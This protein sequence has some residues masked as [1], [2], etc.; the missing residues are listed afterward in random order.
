[1]IINSFISLI[2]II[3]I[4]NIF[5]YLLYFINNNEQNIPLLFF[6]FFSLFLFLLFLLVLFFLFFLIFNLFNLLLLFFL[7]LFLLHLDV[8][9]LRGDDVACK[10]FRGASPQGDLLLLEVASVFLIDK[11]EIEEVLD[12]ELAMDVPVSRGQ[13]K[14]PQ[15]K[16]HRD[17]L[18]LYRRSIHNL[19]LCQSL[20]LIISIW[21]Y[22]YYEYLL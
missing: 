11:N 16:S 12:R 5:F 6:P 13:V 20:T 3:F 2:I 14:V 9:E 17:R 22:I 8:L 7:L 18:A 4:L 15:E 19:K 10:L 21:C 1:M